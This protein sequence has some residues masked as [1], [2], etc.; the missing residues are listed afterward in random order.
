MRL[1][2]EAT[3]ATFPHPNPRVGAVLSSPDGAI[4]SVTAHHRAGAAH[5]EV[6]AL[7]A[8]A[9]AAG[10]TLHVTLEPCNHDGRTPPC[11]DA[12]IEAGIDKVFV[13]VTDPDERVAGSG[14]ER[15]REAGIEVITGAL[16]DEIIANDPGYYH[17]RT[18][19]LPLV[20]LKLAATLDGQVGAADGTSKWI[21]SPESREDAHRLRGAN[22]VVIVGVGTI[23][24]DDPLLDVRLDGYVGPQPRPVIMAGA[25]SIPP[26]RR[27][28]DRDP[29][30]YRPQ[31]SPTVDPVTVVKDLGTRGYVS[32]MV[33]GGPTIAAAFLNAGLV[34]RLVWYTAAKLASGRGTPAVAGVFETMADITTID[35][36]DVDRVGP[37]IRITATITKER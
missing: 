13:G 18:T 30:V 21:T 23:I 37:D 2:L 26:D 24:A 1:A 5:A 25:R 4:L 6:L 36:T 22:D 32:A 35:I 20:T 9:D 12:I 29:I 15:L 33:E 14:I 17:H 3:R 28:L 16:V 7:D 10:G 34:D 31:G 11:T 27:V 19:G 8:V